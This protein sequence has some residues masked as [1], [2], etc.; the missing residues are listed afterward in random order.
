MKERLGGNI[1]IRSSGNVEDGSKAS[2]A[3]VFESLY[4]RGTKVKLEHGWEDFGSDQAAVEYVVR[5][6]YDTTR[7]DGAIEYFAKNDVKPED[8]KM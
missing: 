3:G 6:I 4:I 2:A 7:S 1:A 5:K 8:I